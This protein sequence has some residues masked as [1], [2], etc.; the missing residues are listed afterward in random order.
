MIKINNEYEEAYFNIYNTI[1][2]L[3]DLYHEKIEAYRE[4][5]EFDGSVSQTFLQ[6]YAIWRTLRNLVSDLKTL[7][8]CD[9]MFNEKKKEE[10]K[11]N[12]N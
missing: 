2:S 1:M 3:K 12:D 8:D 5:E 10:Q 6:D 7:D 4:L 9:I 11:D